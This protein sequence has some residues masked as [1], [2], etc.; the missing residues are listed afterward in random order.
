MRQHQRLLTGIFNS[1]LE[2]L[3]SRQLL[4][5]TADISFQP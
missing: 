4:A 2:A 3:E 5:F 1:K